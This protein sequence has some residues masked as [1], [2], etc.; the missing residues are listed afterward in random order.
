MVPRLVGAV[1]AAQQLELQR[2]GRALAR[3]ADRDRLLGDGRARRGGQRH[4][5]L[6]VLGQADG[7]HRV[8]ERERVLDIEHE[9]SLAGLAAGSARDVHRHRLA[10]VLAG[11]GEVER[12]VEA[13]VLAAGVLEHG[14][15]RDGAAAALGDLG[16]GGA[17]R[18]LEAGEP[19]LLVD[20]DRRRRGGRL[21]GHRLDG[22][23]R[24]AS[25]A[26]GACVAA[27]LPPHAAT[28]MASAPAIASAGSR[29]PVS[30]AVMRFRM[31]AD[32]L[33]Q[34]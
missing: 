27:A 15:D 26:A 1:L 5:R 9:R 23:R 31:V 18:H 8:V 11:G 28:E 14:L 10:G 20:L 13:A 30:P 6:L 34:G 17:E 22:D 7:Q 2:V 32:L 3:R 12:A 33:V 29:R 16:R 4:D 21:G 24:G 19:D 25:D